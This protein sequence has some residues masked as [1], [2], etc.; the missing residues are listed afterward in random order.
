MPTTI[1]AFFWCRPAWRRND[2]LISQ[3]GQAAP[4]VRH[5]APAQHGQQAAARQPARQNRD[6]RRTR[7]P[8]HGAG[9][10]ATVPAAGGCRPDPQKTGGSGRCRHPAPGWPSKADPVRGH[11]RHLSRKGSTSAP[12]AMAARP[13]PAGRRTM[14]QPPQC[15]RDHRRNGDPPRD[16][17]REPRR[18]RPARH[19]PG[20]GG[21]APKRADRCHRPGDDRHR[22][23]RRLRPGSNRPRSPPQRTAG[24]RG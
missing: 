5:R 22:K 18:Y 9:A 23:A 4:V 20:K 1:T 10:A 17:R 3:T 15:R 7:P 13:P 16:I 12:V 21:P 19:R 11:A 14:R 6:R 24:R 2:A 8:P